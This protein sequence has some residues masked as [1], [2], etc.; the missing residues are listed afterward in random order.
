MLYPAL[1]GKLTGTIGIEL[2]AVELAPVTAGRKISYHSQVSAFVVAP[3]ETDEINNLAVTDATAVFCTEAVGENWINFGMLPF[4][5]STVQIL[6]ML[7]PIV[8][9]PAELVLAAVRRT[10]PKLPFLL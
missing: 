1:I 10:N 9:S 4:V 7:V 3:D 2:A 5:A 8:P 6:K